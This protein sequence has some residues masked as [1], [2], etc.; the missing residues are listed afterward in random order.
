MPITPVTASPPA[1]NLDPWFTARKTFD[2]QIKA[3]ANAAAALSDA[4]AAALGGKAEASE[5]TEAL[6]LVQTQMTGIST[7]ANAALPASQKGAANGVAS[8]DAQSKLLASQLPAIA[9]VEYLGAAANQAA[10][11]ALVGQSG[12]WTV[13]TDLGTTWVI[14][15]SNPAQ[16]ASWTQLSYP[17]APVTSV[18]G[19]AGVVVLAKADVG[20]PNVDNTADSAK[21]VSTDQQAAL[22]LK[23]DT[24]QLVVL[25]V[26]DAGETAPSDGVW[27]RRPAV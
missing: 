12:D 20:L 11:L 9:L 16:L 2:D 8:L 18:A 15:G 13:R 4:N 5:V 7:V 17:T 21:P 10:M 26:L 23:A 6:T 1:E 25:G 14:T 27:L 22:D 3:T 19:R 24:T